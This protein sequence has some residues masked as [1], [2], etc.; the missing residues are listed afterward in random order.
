MNVGHNKCVKYCTS[1]IVANVACFTCLQ[2]EGF[3]GRW[4]C[5]IIRTAPSRCRCRRTNLRGRYM[6]QLFVSLPTNK[7]CAFISQ[8]LPTGVSISGQNIYI[9]SHC[10]TTIASNTTT[11]SRTKMSKLH[12]QRGSL[13]ISFCLVFAR[14]EPPLSN[15]GIVV[16]SQ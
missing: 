7:G 4:H 2:H 3:V 11:N 5:Y 6:S 10:K 9:C 16:T 12:Q 13:F 8:Q 14:N 15:F 1:H